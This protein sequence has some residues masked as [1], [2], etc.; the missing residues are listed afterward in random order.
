[1]LAENELTTARISAH[2]AALQRQLLERLQGTPLG[3]AELLNPITSGPH[4]RF[5]AFRTPSAQQWYRDLGAAGCMVDV[6]GDVLRVGLA[7]Y[8]DDADIEHFVA[9]A[10]RLQ[11]D[12]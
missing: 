4:A 12:A 11:S 7:L 10:A 8:H 1:M 5:L 9:L 6:R 2:V 3:D